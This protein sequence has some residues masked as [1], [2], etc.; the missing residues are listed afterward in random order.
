MPFLLTSG[1]W[2]VTYLG[3]PQVCSAMIATA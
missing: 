1:K 3:K 2:Q